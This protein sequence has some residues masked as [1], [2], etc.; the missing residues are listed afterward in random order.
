[1]LGRAGA[2]VTLSLLSPPLR[3]VSLLALAKT[4]EV[5]AAILAAVRITP[6]VQEQTLEERD[7]IVVPVPAAQIQPPAAGTAGE[8]NAGDTP[9][10]L[11]EA[12]I[13]DAAAQRPYPEP[14][15]EVLRRAAQMRIAE[16][17]ASALRTGYWHNWQYTYRP[18]ARRRLPARRALGSGAATGVR[19]SRPP[20]TGSAWSK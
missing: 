17:P 7:M 13:T 11:D 15:P 3:V 5:D 19:Q 20:A 9:R 2:P 14:T 8:S 4:D 18:F 16:I 6:Q 1:M 12:A 10:P